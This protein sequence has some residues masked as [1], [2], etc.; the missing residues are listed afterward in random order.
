MPLEDVDQQALEG[1][2]QWQRGFK[3]PFRLRSKL[4]DVT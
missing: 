4:S 2:A 3:R 1:F